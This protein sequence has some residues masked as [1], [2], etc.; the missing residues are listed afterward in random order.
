MVVGGDGASLGVQVPEPA[1][2]LYYTLRLNQSVGTSVKEQV[3]FS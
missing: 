3:I 1:N 2:M